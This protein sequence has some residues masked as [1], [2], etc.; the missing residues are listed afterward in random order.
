ML[1]AFLKAGIDRMEKTWG[2]DASYMRFVLRASPVS[3]L[4]FAML[5][6]LVDRKAAPAEALAAAGIAGTLAEDCGPC[7]QISVDMAAAGGV[8]EAA[9]D[10]VAFGVHDQRRTDGD[11]GRNRDA[12][13]DFH[14]R[15]P[16]AA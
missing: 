10:A 6:G 7:T 16:L 4:K 14:G 5:T 1:R 15:W 12:A 2:Y 9:R 13:F 8:D 11:A 3:L